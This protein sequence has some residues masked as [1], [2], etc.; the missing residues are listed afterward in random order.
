MKPYFDIGVLG[1]MFGLI[2]L[3]ILF[4]ETKTFL[5]ETKAVQG[6]KKQILYKVSE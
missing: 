2:S 4:I 1:H 6:G 5:V 3:K